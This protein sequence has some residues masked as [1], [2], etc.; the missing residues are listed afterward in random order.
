MP[1]PRDQHACFSGLR[2]TLR[3]TLALKKC[4]RFADSE[5]RGGK[6]RFLGIAE[7]LSG[8]KVEYGRRWKWASTVDQHNAII[9]REHG[10]D[11]A[12]RYILGRQPLE[13]IRNDHAG[14]RA[15]R[16]LRPSLPRGE[17]AASY[18]ERCAQIRKRRSQSESIIEEHHLVHARIS[19]SSHPTTEATRV[20]YGQAHATGERKQGE[21][22]HESD[23]AGVCGARECANKLGTQTET[24]ERCSKKHA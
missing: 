12:V 17:R 13:G 1:R 20:L 21:R 2:R 22:K 14:E 19:V 5:V 8:L 15:I 4:D 9:R 6:M 11:G 16:H 3:K 7:P 10:I 23:T 18:I 24:R